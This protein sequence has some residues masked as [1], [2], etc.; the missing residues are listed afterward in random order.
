MKK[1]HMSVSAARQLLKTYLL[2]RSRYDVFLLLI[3]ILGIW[4]RFY[5]FPERYGFDFDAS[6]DANIA[7]YGAR[8][9]VFPG[10]GPASAL[11]P[12]HFGPWYYYQL[13]LFQLLV[14]VLYAPWIYIG[15]LSC[16]AIVAAYKV[17]ESVQSKTLGLIMAAFVSF[18]PAQIAP[19]TGLSNPNLVVLPS[20]LALWLFIKLLQDKLSWKWSFS[21][22]LILGIG[23]NNHYQML[24]L[25]L[26][27]VFL[28]FLTKQA[29][30]TYLTSASFGFL[31]AF[32]P[33]LWFEISHGFLNLQGLFFYL[34]EGKN[35]VYIP[36]SWTLYLRDFWPAFLMNTSGLPLMGVFVL[37]ITSGISFVLLLKEKKLHRTLL[38]LL[39]VFIIEFLY[40]RYFSAN[41]ESYYLLYLHPFLFLFYAFGLSYAITLKKHRMIQLVGLILI[42][43]ALSITLLSSLQTIRSPE[44]YTEV[45]TLVTTIRKQYAGRKIQLFDCAE[46][47]RGRSMGVLY[48]LDAQ[49]M[50]DRNG[51]KIGLL[52]KTNCPSGI[53]GQQV[54]A[55]VVASDIDISRGNLKDYAIIELHATESAG[56]TALTGESLYQQSMHKW[57]QK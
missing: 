44:S 31:V 24:P 3:V 56:F 36:N 49:G 9:L 5:N 10:L 54:S 27:P 41:R 16:G 18:S 50:I 57:F 19:G 34:T 52:D 15:I 37:L 2:S 40:L 26:L 11:G 55:S 20:L 12:F 7:L 51:V 13:I 53:D 38:I 4:L 43:A 28:F 46:R 29:K 47:T 35:A 42:T 48:L 23:I 32:L 21:F 39:S 22:A 14:P 17:G 6:R 25:L 30:K 45:T 1:K 33:L 8:A